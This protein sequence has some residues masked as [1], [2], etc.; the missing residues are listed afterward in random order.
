MA[1]S[2]ITGK[3]KLGRR[4]SRTRTSRRSAGRTSTSR[5]AAFGSPSRPLRHA[6]PDDARHPHDR[7]DRRDR[8]REASRRR[9]RL[10]TPS[11]PPAAAARYESF[12][13]RSAR[14]RLR[15]RTAAL[16]ELHAGPDCGA[17][18]AQERVGR[19]L[20]RQ[21]EPT[22]GSPRSRAARAS[23]AVLFTA[24]LSGSTEAA[25]YRLLDGVFVPAKNAHLGTERDEHV[26]QRSV[27]HGRRAFE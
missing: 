14:R 7:Q 5:R 12:A 22:V 9:A 27:H 16:V 13:L 18:A 4:T 17:L 25:K 8:V 3:R 26:V 21:S 2:D 24:A 11:F 20:L 19:Q 15:F 6:Q 1:K 10:D 23:R